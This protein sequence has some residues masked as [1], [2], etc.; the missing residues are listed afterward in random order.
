MEIA[1]SRPFELSRPM[2]KW[3]PKLLFI[4]AT[5]RFS[6]F[7]SLMSAT[8]MCCAVMNSY[9]Y[10][11]HRSTTSTN[12]ARRSFL[13]CRNA[14]MGSPRTVQ[15]PS[16]RL[17]HHRP[18]YGF[19][20]AISICTNDIRC[21]LLKFQKQRSYSYSTS[22]SFT[23][24][25]CYSTSTSKAEEEER[26]MATEENSSNSTFYSKEYSTFQHLGVQSE[27]LLQRLSNL[28]FTRPSTIQASVFRHFQDIRQHTQQSTTVGHPTSS[29]TNF[30]VGAET[31]SGKTL[32]Y[33]L[34]LIDD[35]L[36]RKQQLQQEQSHRQQGIS[37]PYDYARAVILV[38]NKE[39]AQQILRM[40][41]GLCAQNPNQA[42]VYGGSTTTS[43]SDFSGMMPPT[44]S[45][46]STA[47]S[48]S[49]TSEVEE[50]LY[51]DV[52]RVALLPGNLDSPMDF[53]PFRE[54]IYNRSPP[55]DLLICTP[56]ALGP[57]GLSPKNIPFF[58]DVQTL[59]ID[60]ADMLLD[61]GF[62]RDLDN[63]FLGFRRADRLD[64]TSWEDDDTNEVDLKQQPRT[65][66]TGATK[67]QHIFVGATIPNYGLKSVDAYIAKK[68]PNIQRLMIQGMHHARHNGLRYETLWLEDSV[69]TSNDNNNRN[70]VRM[71]QLVQMLKGNH[72][73]VD[74]RKEKVMIFL[75]S[76]EDVDGATNA[77]R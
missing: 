38:P 40:A 32:A 26:S 72:A 3:N 28:G 30:I 43:Y 14:W 51:R 8:M 5:P 65:T 6:I 4:S 76:I 75:N 50:D 12:C 57:W 24:T 34:P 59:V 49:N 13:I 60:E 47:A 1:L 27:V 18:I 68:F 29:S 31:G 70:K 39:L 35:I 10:V 62:K 15:H 69:T 53:K 22:S 37:M 64:V 25:C 66:A 11:F 48:G 7:S 55:V 77:L 19:N 21:K 2:S 36:V 56:A 16:R 58:L 73:T 23:N 71:E 44:G 17:P 9:G 52:V 74:L 20:D 54:T 67:T 61:G 63:I 41:C 33:L 46:I 45:S 42:I